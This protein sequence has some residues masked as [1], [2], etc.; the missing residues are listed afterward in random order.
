MSAPV[1][2]DAAASSEPTPPTVAIP[3]PAKPLPTLGEG[4]RDLLDSGF[5]P[6]KIHVVPESPKRAPDED[7]PAT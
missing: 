2:D 4:V 1:R 3:G 5:V 7:S 6:V